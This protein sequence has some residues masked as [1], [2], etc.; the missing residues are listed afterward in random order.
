MLSR[1]TIL[2]QQKVL[3][4]WLTSVATVYRPQL[5]DDGFGVKTP[6][7][8]PDVTG[9]LVKMQTAT[10]VPKSGVD[11]KQLGVLTEWRIVCPVGIVV[12]A[13]W[14]IGVSGRMFEIED[15]DN[16]TFET[17]SIVCFCFDVER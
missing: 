7:F 1:S 10:R 3:D 6:G 15:V 9:I 11:P 2:A 14:R 4:V 5:T 17:A 12:K 13:G 16:L 8:T